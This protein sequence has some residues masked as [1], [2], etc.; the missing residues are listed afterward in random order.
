MIKPYDEWNDRLNSYKKKDDMAD[1]FL[2]GIYY[3]T[4][5]YK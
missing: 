5:T 1:C 2:Q 4:I 3:I